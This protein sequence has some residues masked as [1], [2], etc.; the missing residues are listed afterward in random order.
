[1]RITNGNFTPQAIEA[2][3]PRRHLDAL[4]V[5][6]VVAHGTLETPEFQ[7]QN[8][9]FAAAVKAVGKMADLIVLNGYNHFEVEESLGNPYGLLGRSLL[10]QMKLLSV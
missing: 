9:E 7:R 3:S 6:V 8:K 4:T 10:R 5:P 1:M 2:L